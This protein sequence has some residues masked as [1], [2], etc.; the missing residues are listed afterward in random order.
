MAI[1][2]SRWWRE[3]IEREKERDRCGFNGR[4]SPLFIGEI[5]AP[6]R[7]LVLFVFEFEK[8]FKNYYAVVLDARFHKI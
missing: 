1:G 6:L 4:E 2:G 5:F 7:L 3:V 8:Y